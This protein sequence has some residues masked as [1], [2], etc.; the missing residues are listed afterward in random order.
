MADGTRHHLSMI[1]LSSSE[2]QAEAMNRRGSSGSAGASVSSKVTNGRS[3]LIVPVLL[4]F[5]N[6]P[7]AL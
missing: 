1:I 2:L 5:G 4:C 7:P 3:A 6:P